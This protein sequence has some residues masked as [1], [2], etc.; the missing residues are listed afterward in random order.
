MASQGNRA[1][2]PVQRRPLFNDIGWPTIAFV[3]LVVI[4]CLMGYH[5]QIAYKYLSLVDVFFGILLA[6][7][8]VGIILGVWKASF[9]WKYLSVALA[10]VWLVPFVLYVMS[11]AG[12]LFDTHFTL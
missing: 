11:F 1:N 9:R 2:K 12:P 6:I 10:V 5:S 3:S 4:F 8:I 7:S